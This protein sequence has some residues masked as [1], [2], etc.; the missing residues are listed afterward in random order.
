M[1]AATRAVIER[2]VEACLAGKGHVQ[3]A[4]ARNPQIQHYHNDYAVI[5]TAIAEARKLL[6]DDGWIRVED[7]LPVV[8]PLYAEVAIWMVDSRFPNPIRKTFR[9][10]DKA[11]HQYI[12]HWQYDIQPKPPKG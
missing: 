7:A 12:T 8:P 2:L 6:E 3:T 10:T 5:A 9:V 4:V 1:N 11:L